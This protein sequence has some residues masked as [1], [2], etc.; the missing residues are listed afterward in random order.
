MV[1]QQLFSPSV[2]LRLRLGTL[3]QLHSL[4][5]LP[6]MKNPFAITAFLCLSLTIGCGKPQLPL[7]QVRGRL[8]VDGEPVAAAKIRFEPVAG[9]RPSFA[10]SDRTGYYTLRYNARRMGALPGEHTVRVTTFQEAYEPL[11][12]EDTVDREEAAL[13]ESNPGRAEE[14]PTKYFEDPLTVTVV[15]GSNTIDLT[16]DS[17]G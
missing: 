1:R 14:I 13:I 5:R 12:G 16:L 11:E 17:D 10:E 6:L 15:E 3:K 8:T 7:G 4:Q 9:G 2:E